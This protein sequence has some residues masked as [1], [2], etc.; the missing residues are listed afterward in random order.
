MLIVLNLEKSI[1]VNVVQFENNR[2][3]F[4]NIGLVN[5]IINSYSPSFV[6][7]YMN[8]KSI[9][10]LFKYIWQQFSI[11]FWFELSIELL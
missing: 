4:F 1:F 5:L 7:W 10:V 6:N 2:L 3:I 11:S 8:W 9:F